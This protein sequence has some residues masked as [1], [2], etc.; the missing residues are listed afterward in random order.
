MVIHLLL[1]E[2]EEDRKINKRKTEKIGRD[3][4]IGKNLESLKIQHKF[5][6]KMQIGRG[7]WQLLR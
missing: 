3:R 5:I 7:F 2:E 6:E 1:W 4:D